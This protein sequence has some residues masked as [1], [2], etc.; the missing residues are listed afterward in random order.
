MAG[1]QL[2]QKCPMQADRVSS[3]PFKYNV[4]TTS[5][6]QTPPTTD[7]VYFVFRD[8][9]DSFKSSCRNYT[10]PVCW[11][12]WIYES[13]CKTLFSPLYGKAPPNPLDTVISGTVDY[14]PQSSSS[15][16]ITMQ[17]CWRD[18]RDVFLSQYVKFSNA[19]RTLRELSP[20][21]SVLLKINLLKKN[22]QL[23]PLLLVPKKVPPL[24][25]NCTKA[26]RQ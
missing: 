20:G 11:P 12:H 16:F 2:F 6:L 1:F 3:D 24:Y 25:Q 14:S 8:T 22:P 21:N 9:A 17:D 10:M 18:D 5:V 23:E 13:L 4:G 15:L 19:V 7:F 26:E